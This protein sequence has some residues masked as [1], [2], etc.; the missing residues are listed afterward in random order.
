MRSQNYILRLFFC[1]LLREK[2][3]PT[4]KIDDC[5]QNS[6]TATAARGFY[7]AKKADSVLGGK[8]KNINRRTILQAFSLP[9]AQL[10][11]LLDKSCDIA[12]MNYF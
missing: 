12:E 9:R 1:A 2:E 6:S 10:S 4:K 7:Y 11:S 5:A 3:G 8:K